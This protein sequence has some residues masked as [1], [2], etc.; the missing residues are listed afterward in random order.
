MTKTKNKRGPRVPLSE[1]PRMDRLEE[2]LRSQELERRETLMDILI[3]AAKEEPD[4]VNGGDDGQKD[5]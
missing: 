5:V 2:I 3:R 4:T 1:D